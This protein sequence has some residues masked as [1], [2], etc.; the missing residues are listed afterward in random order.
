MLLTAFELWAYRKTLE[1]A[2]TRQI[3][4]EDVL[5]MLNLTGKEV[6]K[7]VIERETLYL[8]HVLMRGGFQRTILQGKF[9]SKRCR[10]GAFTMRST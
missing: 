6:V 7:P 10:A 8:G 3:Q 4:K 2:W 5:P 1:L 9:D